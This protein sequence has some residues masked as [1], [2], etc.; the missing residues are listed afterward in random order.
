MY[1]RPSQFPQLAKYIF[2][3]LQK[4][5]LVHFS[6]EE[7]SLGAIVSVFQKNL[8]EENRLNDEARRLLETNKKKLGLQIDEEKALSMIKKQLAKERNFTL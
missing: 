6:S 8:E 5:G 7:E 2:Q 3:T 4:G 1:L